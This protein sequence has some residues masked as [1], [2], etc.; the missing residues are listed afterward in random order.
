MKYNPII[1]FYTLKSL[2]DIATV[3][4]GPTS[5]SLRL[6]PKYQ[7]ATPSIIKPKIIAKVKNIMK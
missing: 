6:K 2:F 5:S 7:I 4:P 1:I 3:Y